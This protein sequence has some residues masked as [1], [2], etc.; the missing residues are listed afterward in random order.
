MSLKV[1]YLD[2]E[3]ELCEIFF[4]GF[5]SD[6]I[7]IRVYSEPLEAIESSKCDPPDVIFIDYRMAGTRGDIVAQS[8]PP[9]T[10]KYLLT[11][12]NTI[13]TDYPF[14]EVLSKL[15]D[16]SR[17]GEILASMAAKKAADP[18]G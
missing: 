3:T 1:L 14:V 12:D 17:I 18:S 11:G 8:M 16:W 5:S 15:D 10:P 2:D 9:Q 13:Q 6:S 7:H 4:D